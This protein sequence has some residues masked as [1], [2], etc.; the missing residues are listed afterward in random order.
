M[1]QSEWQN[2]ILTIEEELLQRAQSRKSLILT[3]FCT[4]L[5]LSVQEFFDRHPLSE[6]FTTVTLDQKAFMHALQLYDVPAALRLIANYDPSKG[7]KTFLSGIQ[8]SC[9]SLSVV[10]RLERFA[11]HAA[12][13]RELASYRRRL[14]NSLTRVLECDRDLLYQQK[15]LVERLKLVPELPK[16]QRDWF[17]GERMRVLFSADYRT[18]LILKN[19]F[20]QF[21]LE[22]AERDETVRRWLGM[23]LEKLLSGKKH[24]ST[25][26]SRLEQIDF[27]EMEQL[28]K[29]LMTQ[30]GESLPLVADALEPT[31]DQT[32]KVPHG[33]EVEL[34]SSPQEHNASAVT[35]GSFS[36]SETADLFDAYRK[37]CLKYLDSLKGLSENYISVDECSSPFFRARSEDYTSDHADFF[38]GFFN[39][40]K[41]T[42][43]GFRGFV[44]QLLQQRGDE[45]RAVERWELLNGP[46]HEGFH[47]RHVQGA[48]GSMERRSEW[49]ILIGGRLPFTVRYP[50][51]PGR[52]IKLHKN[53]GFVLQVGAAFF[54]QDHPGTLDEH[55]SGFLKLLIGG[56]VLTR[57]TAVVYIGRTPYFTSTLEQMHLCRG[58]LL[59]MLM[60]VSHRFAIEFSAPMQDFLVSAVP[61]GIEVNGKIRYQP[62]KTH[63]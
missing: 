6:P 39:H 18:Y 28:V 4:A 5:N 47:T 1:H 12:E 53:S 41:E 19:R 14:E 17:F 59:L 45:F 63:A 20:F 9:Q 57:K 11:G 34:F 44:I 48:F 22:N 13:T 50:L 27:R 8:K 49:S 30:F 24:G 35:P 23:K 43:A 16:E 25:L 42:A 46:R 40:G 21:R 60:G 58:L 61:A 31:G 33:Q 26:A 38:H 55:P 15:S 3:R 36:I 54:D 37:L 56:H 52:I 29:D 2:Q 51:E 7:G 62:Y 10:R 32:R